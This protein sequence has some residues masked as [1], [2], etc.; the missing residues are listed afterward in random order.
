ERVERLREFW[1]T[2]C[3]A[4]VEWP[5]SERLFEALPFVFDRRSFHNAMAAMWALFQGQPGFF[6]PRFPPPLW[7]PFS[8]DGATSFYDTAPLNQTLERLVDFDRLNSG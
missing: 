6:K 7:S 4:P 5:A 3:A 8:G 2:I 1:E